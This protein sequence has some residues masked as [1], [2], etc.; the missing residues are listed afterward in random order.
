MLIAVGTRL[1]LASPVSAQVTLLKSEIV[2]R[3]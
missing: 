1:C 2:I 3:K